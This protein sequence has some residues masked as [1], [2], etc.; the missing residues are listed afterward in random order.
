M[1]SKTQKKYLTKEVLKECYWKSNEKSYNTSHCRCVTCGLEKDAHR[2]HDFITPDDFFAVVR[3]LDKHKT[4][5]AID[6]W[7]FDLT[8]GEILRQPDFIERFMVEVCRAKG[9]R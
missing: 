6:S 2:Y 7:P 8:I 3:A 5:Y 1:L 4:D 9:V